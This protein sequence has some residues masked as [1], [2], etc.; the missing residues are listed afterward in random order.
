MI[1]GHR[2]ALVAEALDV[3]V[4]REQAML[5]VDRAQDAFALGHLQRAE[6][7]AALDRL[8]L[9]RLV[10]GDDDGAGDRRQV[11]RL[12]ALLVVLDQLV[13]LAADDRALIGLLARGDAPLEQIPVDLRR[14][15]RR[16]LAAAADR[17][18]LFAV[19]EHLEPHELVDVVGRERCLVE[20]HP[21][22][23]HPDGGDADHGQVASSSGCESWRGFILCR[24]QN[25]KG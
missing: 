1:A 3:G 25:I 17:L 6:R 12:P 13:D 24:R 5:A 16:L 23:L 21:E 19:V 15:G 9:Q 7:R 18:R 4:Q 22:L 10:A 14:R 11:A 2:E 20:L 8:E